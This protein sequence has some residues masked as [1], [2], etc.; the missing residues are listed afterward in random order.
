MK[1]QQV[2]TFR[3]TGVLAVLWLLSLM[4]IAACAGVAVPLGSDPGAASPV[5]SLGPVISSEQT[6]RFPNTAVTAT[7][8]AIEALVPPNLP[9]AWIP[10]GRSLDG[11]SFRSDHRLPWF[12]V[13]PDTPNDGDQVLRCADG[14]HILYWDVWRDQG[15]ADDRDYHEISAPMVIGCWH[16][17]VREDVVAVGVH[18]PN[19]PDQHAGH[20]QAWLTERQTVPPTADSL[21]VAET[22]GETSTQG[23]IG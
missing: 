15:K 22:Q 23:C 9:A 7:A 19:F 18:D 14:Y 8:Q 11:H 20:Y 4:S 12:F 3:L 10:H 5:G 6:E 16:D 13:F 2:L 21:F 17:Q 1:K